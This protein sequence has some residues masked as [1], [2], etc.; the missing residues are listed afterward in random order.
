MTFL[1]FNTAT[2]ALA[3]YLFA[4]PEILVVALLRGWTLMLLWRWFVRPALQVP[5]LSFAAAAGIS[6]V[7]HYLTYQ[8]VDCAQPERS[9]SSYLLRQFGYH[10]IR[11]LVVLSVGYVL[12][13]FL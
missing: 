2:A 1:V 13:L 12:T 8:D 4:L 7:V 5:V 11:P 9:P 6:L 3:G 10:L